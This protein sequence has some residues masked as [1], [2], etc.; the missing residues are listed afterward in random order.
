MTAI[1]A[2]RPLSMSLLRLVAVAASVVIGFFLPRLLGGASVAYSTL[3]TIAIFA[4]MCYGAD[5]VLS[6]L[7]EVSLGHTLFWAIGGYTAANL[8]VKYG[9][10]G[11][12]TAATAVALCVAA[13]AFLGGSP[14]DPRIRFLARHLRGRRRRLRNRLQLGRDRRLR[15]H[16]R[17]SALKLPF[18]VHEI[19]GSIQ[20]DLAGSLHSASAH[21]GLHR[22]LSSLPA[23]HDCADGADEPGARHE[24]WRRS[25]KSGSRYS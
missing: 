19:P 6:Y 2:L 9:L 1:E 3:T 10:N 8:S 11:W 20:E 5:I 22:A 21:A 15:W 24:P 7:G 13:A 16:R 18:D 14:P 25:P 4:V 12:V 17:H 23:R